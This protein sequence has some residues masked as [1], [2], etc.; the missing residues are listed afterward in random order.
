MNLEFVRHPLYR[1]FQIAFGLVLIGW[2]IA[3]GYANA[4]WDRCNATFND[5]DAQM[6]ARL[7]AL[8]ARTDKDQAR[9]ASLKARDPDLAKTLNA[10]QNGAN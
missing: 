6:S 8:Q 2:G 3:Y 7:T 1:A 10:P 9:E 5:L 4:Q